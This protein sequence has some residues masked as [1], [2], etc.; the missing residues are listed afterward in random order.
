MEYKDPSRRGRYIV[1]VGVILAVVAGGAAFYLINQA[2]EQAGQ[3]GLQKVA[4][5][6]ALQTIPARKIIEPT[7][8]IV[9]EVPIDPTNAQARSSS[10]TPKW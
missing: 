5:V 9:R 7:D 10:P 2:Q 1:V 8:V 4:V 3:A 6:V